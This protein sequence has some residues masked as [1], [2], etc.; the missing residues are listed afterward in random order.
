MAELIRDG[1]QQ[2]AAAFLELATSNVEQRR[3]AADAADAA[4]KTQ[5]RLERIYRDAMPGLFALED[6]RQAMARQELYRR[7]MHISESVIATADRVW[8]ALMKGA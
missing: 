6:L 5:R 2:L 8:Y 3:R 4:I 1:V 7:L